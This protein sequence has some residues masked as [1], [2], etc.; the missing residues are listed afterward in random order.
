MSRALDHVD[1]AIT[2]AYGFED[3]MLPATWISSLARYVLSDEGPYMAWR[4]TILSRLETYYRLDPMEKLG[5]VIPREAIDPDRSFD[6][7]QT[8]A[9]VRLQLNRSLAVPNRFL[10]KPESMADAGFSGEPYAFDIQAERQ[11][12][13]NW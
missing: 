4:E 11:R 2:T 7:S 3:P 5:E 12:R 1:H 10:H 13:T 6:P 8:E 9:L